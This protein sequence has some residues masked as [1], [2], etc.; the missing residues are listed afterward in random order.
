M[1][2]DVRLPLQRSVIFMAMSINSFGNSSSWFNTGTSKSSSSSGLDAIYS[3]LTDNSLIRNGTYGKLMKAY[4]GKS[5]SKSSISEEEA[6]ESSAAYSK[7]KSG[8]DSLKSA[9]SAL[10]DADLYK[11]GSYTVTSSDGSKKESEY[12]YD[13]IYDKLNDFVKSYNSTLSSAG[14]EEA[15]KANKTALNMVSATAA[16]SDLLKK[17]G[18]TSDSDGKLSIDRDKLNSAD[19]S[20]IKSL[21]SNTGS[22]GSTIVNKAEV[23]S[24]TAE[25]ELN[26][27]SKISPSVAKNIQKSSTAAS[28]SKT[29]SDSKTSEKKAYSTLK[30]AA[31]SV[32]SSVKEIGDSKLYRK[33]NYQVT[34]SNGNKSD[35]E[36]DLDTLY[37]K[38]SDF[39]KSYNSM[40]TA[41]ASEQ[42]ESANKATLRT[43]QL[44]ASYAGALSIVGITSDEDG[45]L[46]IDR[47]K[48][49][50]GGIS[51]IKSLF[52]EN[53]SYAEKVASKASSVEQIASNKIANSSLYDSDAN[54]TNTINQLSYTDLV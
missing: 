31:E 16:N 4:Y 32:K 45:K 54:L 51:T 35:S 29:A 52:G 24:K 27:L 48:F 13:K 44:T 25:T 39:I 20:T 53:N 36:Y 47:D 23:I 8:A 19:V 28:S 46:S 22:Y 5:D 15:S 10:D 18:I 12:D 17:I 3:N 30:S 14:S 7:V 34:D 40:I 37:N 43:I 50:S 21:F 6:E 26:K 1:D 11:K 49:N 38:A 41:G 42:A 33:G 2:T 9:A